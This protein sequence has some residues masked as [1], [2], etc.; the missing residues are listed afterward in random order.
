MRIHYQEILKRNI[1]FVLFIALSVLCGLTTLVGLKALLG[2]K[3][4]L[5]IGI[6]ANGT[7]IVSSTQDPIYKTEAIQFIQTFF[8]NTYNFNQDNFYKRV[9]VA[10]TY[11]SE[12]L[13]K[14][15]QSEILD[16]KMRV[17]KDQIELMSQIKKLSKDDAGVFHG[18]LEISERTRL[19]QKEHTLKVSVRLK[20]T[21]RTRNN[22]YGLEVDSYEE[23]LIH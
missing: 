14:K 5:I 17:E 13:W 8:F 10:T 11:M 20:S 15:K 16:L 19:N 1:Q 2:Q 23:T 18:L 6:D 4:P 12:D 7:R 3:E 21:E 22:P 9:G